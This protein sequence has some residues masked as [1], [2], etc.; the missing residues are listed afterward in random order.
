M[1]KF[2]KDT[3]VR[4]ADNILVP[5]IELGFSENVVKSIM[6]SPTMQS[7]LV[8]HS[9]QEF[10]EYHKYGIEDFSKLIKHSKIPVRF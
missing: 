8:E 7:D 4:H 1:K 9:I 3:N 10:M 6:I 2:D 5:Y